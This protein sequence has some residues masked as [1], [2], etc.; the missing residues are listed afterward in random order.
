M[1]LKNLHFCY[2]RPNHWEF[3]FTN[4]KY[5]WNNKEA[6]SPALIKVSD[7]FDF[8]LSYS[9]V[10]Y[11]KKH[12]LNASTQRLYCCLLD[13]FVVQ[14]GILTGC[15]QTWT[16]T[17]KA[18]DWTCSAV[19][20]SVWVIEYLVLLSSSFLVV[21]EDVFADVLPALVFSRD[22]VNSSFPE[23][24]AAAFLIPNR[25]RHQNNYTQTEGRWDLP[26][27]F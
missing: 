22:V 27:I 3:N 7:C 12:K 1:T 23:L 6:F 11:K 24:V 16:D 20:V 15:R 2:D 5:C 9:S 17:L 19:C 10:L 13:N 26:Y 21:V 4:W 25:H 14:W 8:T 18:I